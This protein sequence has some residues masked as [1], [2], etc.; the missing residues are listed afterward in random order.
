MRTT[1]D[2]DDDVLR[3]VKELANSR[4]STAGEVLSDL[5]RRA[6][7]SSVEPS[8]DGPA[9]ATLKNG[10]YVLPSRG[11]PP[12]T[13]ELVR[14]LLEEADLEDAGLRSKQED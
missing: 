14:H 8:G 5:A 12:V 9:G 10:W 6:L 11:G 7:T 13:S 1:L 2:I 3:A 4:R